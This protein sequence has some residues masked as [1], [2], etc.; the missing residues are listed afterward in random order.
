MIL[1]YLKLWPY[2]LITLLVI[3]CWHYRGTA[4]SWHQTA[5]E[6]KTRADKAEDANTTLMTSNAQL[7]QRNKTL[8]E[9]LNARSDELEATQKRAAADRSAYRKAISANHSWASERVPEPVADI[10]RNATRGV[11][12]DS[13][14]KGTASK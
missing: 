12:D 7:D 10:L 1:R 8:L 11:Q 9:S 6:Q 3:G 4:A 14:T 2:A 5:T 13:S